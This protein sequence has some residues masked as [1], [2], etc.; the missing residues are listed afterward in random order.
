MESF[1]EIFEDRTKYAMK[2]TTNEYQSEGAYPVIDHRQKL[3]AA[4]TDL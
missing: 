3:I 2:I 4:Y 1:D